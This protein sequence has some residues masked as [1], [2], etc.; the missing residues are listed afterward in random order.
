VQACDAPTISYTQ[1]LR[2]IEDVAASTATNTGAGMKAGLEVL[3]I[4][5]YDVQPS[6]PNDC[7][8]GHCARDDEAHK[9]MVVLT[10]GIPNQNPGG[11]CTAA[12]PNYGLPIGAAPDNAEHRC[13]MY[14]ALEGARRGVTTYVIGLGYSV[15][16]DYLRAVAELGGGYYYFSASGADLELIFEDIRT[17]PMPYSPNHCEVLP[18]A[19][20][21]DALTGLSEGDILF[22]IQQGGGSSGFL[23]T[24]WREGTSAVSWITDPTT[25]EAYLAAAVE[26]PWLSQ[27]DYL[28][29]FD[30]TDYIMTVDDEVWVFSGTVGSAVMSDA[31]T[32]RSGQLVRLPVFDTIFGAGQNQIAH[33]SGFIKFRLTDVDFQANPTTISGLFMGWDNDCGG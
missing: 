10:D 19:I 6:G 20:Q 17:T 15:N 18:L 26:Y 23:F 28:N 27:V 30:T 16:S 12:N 7:N 22:G 33:L 31:L 8:G 13:P 25:S 29:P 3:G 1:V 9:V 11:A 14:F 21:E 2:D 32:A 5:L 4:D 24:R